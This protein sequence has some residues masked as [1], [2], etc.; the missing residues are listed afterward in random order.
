MN[1]VLGDIRVTAQGGVN[2]AGYTYPNLVYE[3][4]PVNLVFPDLPLPEVEAIWNE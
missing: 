2:E 3:F 4:T 1:T